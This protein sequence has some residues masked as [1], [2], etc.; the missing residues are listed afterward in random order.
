MKTYY[1]ELNCKDKNSGALHPL[2]V[3]TLA[4]NED[5]A[6]ALIQASINFTRAQSEFGELKEGILYKNCALFPVGISKHDMEP[7]N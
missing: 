1:F 3:S 2:I 4:E 6:R 5:D 7:M